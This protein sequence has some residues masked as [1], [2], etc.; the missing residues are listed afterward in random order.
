MSSRDPHCY[1]VFGGSFDPP[2]IAHVLVACWA[3]L[4]DEVD[5]V[6]V[7]PTFAHAF[8]KRS[9]SYEHR[10]AMCGRA[11]AGVRN[12]EI[13]DIER[14]LGGESRTYHTLRAL[15]EERPGA[16]F[17]LVVGADILEETER[18]FRWEDVAAMAPPLVVGRGGYP[19][20]PGPHVTIEMPELSSTEIRRRLAAGETTRGMLPI[21][22]RRYVDAHGLYADDDDV[23]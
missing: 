16:R 14:R 10:H 22:V 13:C 3:T 18:W 8:G 20:P 9:V 15:S 4:V 23:E 2:H 17:R 21:E 11:M 19:P 5:R 6:L 1:A 12:V 7:V